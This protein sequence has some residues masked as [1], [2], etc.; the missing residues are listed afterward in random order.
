[1]TQYFVLQFNDPVLLSVSL[2]VHSNFYINL[3][4][5]TDPTYSIISSLHI[6]VNNPLG[7]IQSTVLVIILHKHLSIKPNDLYQLPVVSLRNIMRNTGGIY[8]VNLDGTC[9]FTGD[10]KAF[11]KASLKLLFNV[12]YSAIQTVCLCISINK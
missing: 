2:R 1:M 10:T 7:A 11:T 5:S 9:G 8:W 3:R 4:P 6:T 12:I